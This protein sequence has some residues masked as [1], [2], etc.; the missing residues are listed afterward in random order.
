MEKK[1]A[2]F[3]LVK[4]QNQR[5]V[6]NYLRDR[7]EQRISDITSGTGLTYPTV[8]SLLRNLEE[9]G[10]VMQCAELETCGGR[11]GVKYRLNNTYQYGLNLFF[12]DEDLNGIIYD[13]T[14]KQVEKIRFQVTKLITVDEILEKLLCLKSK[15]NSLEIIVLG[16][17][18][19]TLNQQIVYLPAFPNLVGDELA[20]KCKEHLS[21]DFFVENDTNAIAFA[22]R[23][24][25]NSFAHIAYI[26]GCIGVGI[27]YKGEIVQGTHG[28]AGELE[29]LCDDLRDVAKSICQCI[30][31]LVCV[32]DLPEILLSGDFRFDEIETII[33]NE[34]SKT[35]PEERIP[36]ITIVNN[37]MKMYELGLKERI[38]GKWRND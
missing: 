26:Q 11:P 25:R 29:Y 33:Y 10:V 36:K 21:M 22:E 28:Y 16:I 18:G 12:E 14:G 31:A 3:D 20:V 27:V 8:S 38:I 6:R 19:S 32:L 2:H 13:Y 5:I 17:P 4:Q 7:G 30:V 15:Y 37:V 23:K 35:L 24:E 34:L 9:L 1:I